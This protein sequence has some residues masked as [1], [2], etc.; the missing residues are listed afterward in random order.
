MFFA[1]SWA[2]WTQ[3]AGAGGIKS[4]VNF[5]RIRKVN[6]L[7]YYWE[8]Q[9]LPEP[10]ADGELSFKIYRKVD[11]ETFRQ[12]TLSFSYYKLPMGE[13]PVAGTFNPSEEWEYAPPDSVRE[14]TLLAVC[15]D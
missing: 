9:D 15:N 1:A 14:I 2:E 6:G 11:C 7:V 13:G 8:V 10:G 12:M 5:E 3:V 4:Y